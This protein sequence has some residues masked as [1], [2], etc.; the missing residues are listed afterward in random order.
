MM[1]AAVA[2][3]FLSVFGAGFIVGC[4]VAGKLLVDAG[5]LVDPDGRSS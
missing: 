2:A 1:L 4:L 5:I 3:F